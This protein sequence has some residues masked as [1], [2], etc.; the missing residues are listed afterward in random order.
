MR[1][2]D[3]LRAPVLYWDRLAVLHVPSAELSQLRT[4]SPD[5]TGVCRLEW[6]AR[7]CYYFGGYSWYM[8]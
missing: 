8:A 7:S 3:A 5:Q 2:L 6:A 4:I 1:C